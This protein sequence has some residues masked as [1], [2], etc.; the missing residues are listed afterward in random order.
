MLSVQLG[1]A[2]QAS[3]TR[4]LFLL[5]AVTGTL[6]AADFTGKVVAITDG[7]TIKVMHSGTAERIRN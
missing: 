6:L 2:N 3:M 1:S 7:D 5:V 4:R